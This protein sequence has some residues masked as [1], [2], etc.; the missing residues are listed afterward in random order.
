[1]FNT[2]NLYQTCASDSNDVHMYKMEII[3]NPTVGD[4]IA[5]ILNTGFHGI[6]KVYNNRR[7]LVVDTILYQQQV[8]MSQVNPIYND[9]LV[10]SGQCVGSLITMDYV[11]HIQ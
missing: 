9:E 3:G 2:F 7:D 1:M 10:V 4:V 8:I 6:I 11:L 5:E